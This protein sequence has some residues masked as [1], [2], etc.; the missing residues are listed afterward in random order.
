MAST[1]GAR[2]ATATPE[3]ATTAATGTPEVAIEGAYYV[4]VRHGAG[5]YDVAP[6]GRFLMI[7]LGETGGQGPRIN[8]ILNWFEELK[9][10]V[11]TGR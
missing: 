1:V 7:D 6:D 10:R 3:A 4:G 9:Q 5:S 8:V 11:P 2:P